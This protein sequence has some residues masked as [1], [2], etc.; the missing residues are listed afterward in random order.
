MAIAV[1]RTVEGWDHIGAMVGKAFGGMPEGLGELAGW[2]FEPERS[3]GAYDGTALVGHTCVWSLD[4]RVPGRTAPMAGVTMV[5]VLPTYRRRGVAS[6]LL[7]QQLVELHE[8]GAEPVASLSATEPAIYGRYGYGLASEQV[9][10]EVPRSRARMRPIDGVDQVSLRYADPNAVRAECAAV[11][12]AATA[13]RP[14]SFLFTDTWQRRLA[15]DPPALRDGM[16]ELTCVLAERDGELTGFTYYRSKLAW[17]DRGPDGKVQVQRVHAT[18]L[19]SYAALWRYLLDLDLMGT[20]STRVAVDEPLLDLLVDPW[21]AK[22]KLVH[23][24]WVRLV[25][26]DRALAA[27]T[28]AT[29]V[30]VVLEVRD[31]LCPWNARRWRLSGDDSGASCEP[32]SD[33]ADLTL[34]VR[35]LGSVYLGRPSL[36]R[37]AATGLVEEHTP[38]ALAATSRAF[39][40]DPLPSRDT[41]F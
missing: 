2:L 12:A 39:T 1:K 41:V 19:A 5:G 14:G 6:S 20:A 4:M 36:A 35:E 23:G 33:Q 25:D 37:W 24:L 28:Y 29:P 32:T 17:S 27:R 11:H 10:I 15:A 22:P 9:D 8:N 18:D 26:V 16:S 3:L 38:G 30:D 21:A 31:E 34:G 40:S 13:D 7:R